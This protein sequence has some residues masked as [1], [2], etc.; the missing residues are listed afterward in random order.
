LHEYEELAVALGNDPQSVQALKKKLENN[1]LTTPLFDSDLFTQDI[2]ELFSLM[3]E[4]Y[5]NDTNHTS[6]LSS[7]PTSLLKDK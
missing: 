3:Y 7:F 6:F 1:K 4:S 2:E 5:H